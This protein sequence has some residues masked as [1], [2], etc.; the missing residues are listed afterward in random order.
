MSQECECEKCGCIGNEEC[1]A[2][3]PTG[4]CCLDMS[5]ICPCCRAYGVEANK[6]RWSS[7]P[8]NE[9]LNKTVDAKTIDMFEEA[10]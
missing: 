5:C 7:T 3:S 1:G 8:N 9:L 4:N 2:K 6:E 10:Q